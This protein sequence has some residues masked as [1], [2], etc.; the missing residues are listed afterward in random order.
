MEI[1]VVCDHGMVAKFTESSKG[2]WIISARGAERVTYPDGV[3]R[4]HYAMRC[5]RCRINVPVVKPDRYGPFLDW[6]VQ[7]DFV[8]RVSP[9]VVEVQLVGSSIAM[10]QAPPWSVPGCRSTALHSPSPRWIG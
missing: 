3:T 2:V 9:T 7:T 8:T 5:D 1:C 4:W 10:K 6:L